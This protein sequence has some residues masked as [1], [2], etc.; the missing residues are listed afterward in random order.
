MCASCSCFC[1]SH[2]IRCLA[3]QNT[4]THYRFKKTDCCHHRFANHCRRP[5]CANFCHYQSSF[6]GRSFHPKLRPRPRGIPHPSIVRHPTPPGPLPIHPNHPK[7]PMVG[8]SIGPSP[9]PHPRGPIAHPKHR[10][11]SGHPRCHPKQGRRKRSCQGR[12]GRGE[13]GGRKTHQLW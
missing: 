5:M 6:H 8:P 7:H 12:S 9:S 10:R 11:S 13:Q 2:P 3:C 4:R 1:F